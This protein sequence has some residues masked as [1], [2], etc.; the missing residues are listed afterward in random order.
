MMTRDKG[1]GETLRQAREETEVYG[2]S[3]GALGRN[4]GFLKSSAKT[5]ELYTKWLKRSTCV[6]RSV[7]I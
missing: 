5:R 3:W 6:V 1:V 4:A 2:A 7:K